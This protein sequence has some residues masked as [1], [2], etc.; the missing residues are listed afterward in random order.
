MWRNFTPPIC[1]HHFCVGFCGTCDCLTVTVKQIE[2][3]LYRYRICSNNPYNRFSNF[4]DQSNMK[5]VIKILCVLTVVA[6]VCFTAIIANHRLH[7]GTDPAS[8]LLQP[9]FPQAYSDGFQVAFLETPKPV[10]NRQPV[11]RT[12]SSGNKQF[13]QVG[14]VQTAFAPFQ[15][16]ALGPVP[17]V[18][19]LPSPQNGFVN[20]AP[21]MHNSSFH[22]SPGPVQSNPNQPPIAKAPTF[23]RPV[24]VKRY[25][26]THTGRFSSPQPDAWPPNARNV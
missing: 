12:P 5:T 17:T 15:Q 16:P 7:A 4:V 11:P 1:Y 2:S 24:V 23:N 26:A 13:S 14:P 21:T 22:P 19:Q 25:P 18:Q 9:G 3:L 20:S 10:Q 8:T 6:S